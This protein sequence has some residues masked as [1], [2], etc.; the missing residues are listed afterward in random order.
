M[1][2]QAPHARGQRSSSSAGDRR[3]GFAGCRA[4]GRPR[5]HNQS[6]E[7]RAVQRQR[8][9]DLE[10]QKAQDR[11]QLAIDAVKRFGDSVSKN[12]V[13]RTNPELEELRKKLLKEPLAFFK[14]LRQQL[15]ADNDTRREALARLAGAAHELAYLTNEI[16]DK[17]D[18][19]RSYEEA[20]AIFSRLARD[21]PTVL[22]YQ[23]NMAKVQTNIGLGQWLTG[24]PALALESYGQALAIHERLARESQTDRVS[25]RSWHNLQQYWVCPELHG[26]PRPGD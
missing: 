9:L 11:E 3:R 8:A 12:S 21:H 7:H 6:Q 22:A 10:R 15:Q 23:S 14:T 19:L 18:A 24:Q 13:L 17:Q 20:L 16:G 26:P 5:P 25:T 1:G 2:P 4:A